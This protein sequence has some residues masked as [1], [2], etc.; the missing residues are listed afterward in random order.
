MSRRVVA[1]A[2]VVGALVVS[3]GCVSLVR[4]SEVHVAWA[5]ARWPDATLTQLEQGRAVYVARC[6]GCHALHLPSEL[7][8]EDWPEQVREMEQEQ[9]VVLTD[10][11]RTSMLRYLAAASEIPKNPR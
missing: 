3:T 10:D 6:S 9:D 2:V 1:L 8:P 5:T 7:Y 11:E 4:P